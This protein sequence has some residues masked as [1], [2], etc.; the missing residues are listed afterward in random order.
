[1]DYWHNLIL[2]TNMELVAGYPFWLIKDGLLYSYPKLLE[3]RKSDVVIIGGGISGAL[4]AYYLTRAGVECTLVDARTIGL[5]S[6]CASTS[7]LQY[8][9]DTPLHQ[10]KKQIGEDNA[11]RA[12][13]LCAEAIDKL[14]GIMKEIGYGAFYERK[15]LFYSSHKRQKKF[16]QNEYLA[17][18]SAGFEVE[19]LT[20][21]Y[22][23]KNYNLN[24]AYAILSEKGATTD[25]YSLTHEI[26]QYCMQKGLSVFDRTTI[27]TIGYGRDNVVLTTGEGYTMKASQV[28]NA[29]GYEVVNFIGKKI[30]DLDC[31]YAIISE[32]QVE[33]NDLWKD[34]IMMW[35]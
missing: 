10:L 22:L 5:G 4:T 35:N 21:D 26:L 19:V 7:L 1:M 32:S 9:L 3:N 8:E 17:R 31:T 6:T 11:V 33:K 24:A 30:V 34:K 29:T 12:Y 25:A 14:I 18:K 20:G 23:H 28:I 15:S 13:R 27:S 2:K 16:I